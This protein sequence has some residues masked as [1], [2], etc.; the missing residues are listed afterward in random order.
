MPR[1]TVLVRCDEHIAIYFDNFNRRRFDAYIRDLWKK[2]IAN[3]SFAWGSFDG[4]AIWKKITESREYEANDQDLKAFVAMARTEKWKSLIQDQP[5]AAI[6]DLGA[7]IGTKTFA[8][9][10]AVIDLVSTPP[11]IVVVDLTRNFLVQTVSRLAE[12]DEVAGR[13]VK[14]VAIRSEFRD[15]PNV[16]ALML[17]TMIGEGRRLILMTGLT[18]GNLEA[19]EATGVISRQARTGDYVMIGLQ[20]AET[21]DGDLANPEETHEHYANDPAIQ[22]LWRRTCDAVDVTSG[23][24]TSKIVEVGE[25]GF[26]IVAEHHEDE[27]IAKYRENPRVREI[28]RSTRYVQR[29]IIA[30]FDEAGFELVADAGADDAPTYRNMIFQKR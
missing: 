4:A 12:L 5:I 29:D 11:L 20:V 10:Q 13:E 26:S 2:G 17:T 3:P 14:L 7:G 8:I 21:V 24:I 18:F 1:R 25:G 9:G 27:R 16:E 6:I 28:F 15:L 19:D 22:H 23:K 30:M